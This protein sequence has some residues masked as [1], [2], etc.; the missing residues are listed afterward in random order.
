MVVTGAVPHRS[1]ISFLIILNVVIQLCSLRWLHQLVQFSLI[2]SFSFFYIDLFEYL[3][4]CTKFSK[5]IKRRGTKN[6]SSDRSRL[7][8]RN[9]NSPDELQCF[10]NEVRLI[11]AQ[12][13]CQLKRDLPYWVP[14]QLGQMSESRTDWPCPSI[15]N[16]RQIQSLN[17]TQ[18]ALHTRADYHCPEITSSFIHGSTNNVFCFNKYLP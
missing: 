3:R 7:C 13:R 16:A 11:M 18:S 4:V 6:A 5:W 9:R 2:C 14:Y 1:A 12:V 15:S 8:A 10:P 17:W